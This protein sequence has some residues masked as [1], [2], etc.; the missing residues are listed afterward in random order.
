MIH[1]RI[2]RTVI[3]LNKINLK[4]FMKELNHKVLLKWIIYMDNRWLLEL[5]MNTIIKI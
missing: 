4:A 2:N 3:V 5:K 1:Y